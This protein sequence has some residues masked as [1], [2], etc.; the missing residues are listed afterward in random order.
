MRWFS[1][2]LS[3]SL[4]ISFSPANWC[5]FS[6]C[7][8]FVGA[9]VYVS[10][11]KY[12]VALLLKCIIVPRNSACQQ[13]C[14]QLEDLKILPAY[15][16]LVYKRMCTA[17]DL[18]VRSLKQN[19]SYIYQRPTWST[20]SFIPCPSLSLRSLSLSYTHHLLETILP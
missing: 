5:V 17:R 15:M 20:K 19:Q 9:W 18:G 4:S 13:I 7:Q 11:Q 8:M 16:N 1:L 10:A 3:L 14:L 2:S 6:V 12:G